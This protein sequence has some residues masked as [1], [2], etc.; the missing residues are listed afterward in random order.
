MSQSN[1][2]VDIGHSAVKWRTLDSEVFSISIDK[3][4]EKSLPDN[5]SVWLSGGVLPEI[6]KAIEI[7]FSDVTVVLSLIHISEPTGLLSI[8]YAG[9]WV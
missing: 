1:L 3:F 6:V 4:S 2:F 8:A 7:E 9:W 5:Q